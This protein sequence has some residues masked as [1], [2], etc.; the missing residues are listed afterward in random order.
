MCQSVYENAHVE[1]VNGT[2]KNQYLMHWNITSFMQMEKKPKRAVDTCNCKRPHAA[3]DKMTPADY[4]HYI[5]QLSQQDRTQMRIWTEN[6]NNF[7]NEN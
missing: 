6:L 3:L 1:R 5:T 4:E 2:I 7:K